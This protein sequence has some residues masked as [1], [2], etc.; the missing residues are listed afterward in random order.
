MIELQHVAFFPVIETAADFYFLMTWPTIVQHERV[1][2]TFLLDA[3][4]LRN[5]DPFILLLF[6]LFS[7]VMYVIK[8]VKPVDF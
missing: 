7:A 5:N 6:T 3:V 2:D 8:T 1:G 4:K